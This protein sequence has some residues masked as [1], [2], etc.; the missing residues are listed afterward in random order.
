LVRNDFA[1]LRDFAFVR[2]GADLFFERAGLCFFFA[3]FGRDR[4]C[5]VGRG[6]ARLITRAAVFPAAFLIFGLVASAPTTPPITA[7]TGPNMLPIAAPAT[8]PAVSFGIGGISI[9][10]SSD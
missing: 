4:R 5:V 3:A 9:F 10:S 1:F 6:F 8:A 2:L 7:P